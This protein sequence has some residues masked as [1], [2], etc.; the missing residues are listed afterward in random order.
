MLFVEEIVEK[1]LINLSG[2]TDEE[3]PIFYLAYLEQMADMEGWDFFFLYNMDSYPI[4]KQL[5]ASSGDFNSLKVLKSYEDHFRELG[6]KFSSKE[7]DDFLLEAS[8]T[9]YHSCPDWRAMFSKIY[10]ERWK[11]VSKY[12]GSIGVELKI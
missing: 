3:R 9:Y 5:L 8:E 4:V 11:L 6:V 7:I 12:Y 1:G 2:L 10:S